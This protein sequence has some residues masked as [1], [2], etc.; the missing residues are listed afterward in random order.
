MS[1]ETEPATEP[2]AEPAA[3][4][5]VDWQ[6]QAFEEEIGR[7][8]KKFSIKP[9]ELTSCSAHSSIGRY[10]MVGCWMHA[11]ASRIYKRPPC[12]QSWIERAKRLLAEQEKR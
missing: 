8:I 2:A 10:A 7:A 4:P 5:S 11:A 3:E 1:V 9:E 12:P 6:R